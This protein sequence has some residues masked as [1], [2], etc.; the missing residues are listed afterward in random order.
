[1][2]RFCAASLRSCQVHP[3][4]WAADFFGVLEKACVA[5]LRGMRFG[6]GATLESYT[7]IC[8]CLCCNV[9]LTRNAAATTGSDSM[10]Q[11]KVNSQA[12]PTTPALAKIA[13]LAVFEKEDFGVGNETRGFMTLGV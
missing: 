9:S 13:A 6:R 11:E 12:R 1:M 3:S 5:D 8:E 2:A 7:G 4:L 10:P